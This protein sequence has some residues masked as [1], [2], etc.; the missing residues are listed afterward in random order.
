VSRKSKITIGTIVGFAILAILLNYVNSELFSF[1]YGNPIRRVY[2]KNGFVKAEAVSTPEKI[3]QG[4]AGRKELADG[5]GMLFV[6]PGN[7]FQRFWMR[8]MQIPIDIIWIADGRVIGCE[9]NVS[10]E[11]QR[12][13]TSPGRASLVLEVP[14]GFCDVYSVEINDPVG[15]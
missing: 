8:G 1:R 5:R 11:D 7:N 14:G 2:L 9:K 3:E 4:L 10:P 6:M 13:F 12:I 15:F